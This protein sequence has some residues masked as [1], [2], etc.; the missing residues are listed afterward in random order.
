MPVSGPDEREM[1]RLARE[2]WLAGRKAY[3]EYTRALVQ[4]ARQVDH[5]VKGFHTGTLFPDAALSNIVDALGRYSDLLGPWAEAV[6]E[7][8][9]GD[10]ARRDRTA[11]H[12][13][14]VAI[15][16]R[17]REEVA[18]APIGP[19]LRLAQLEQVALIKSLP[20]EAAL[21]VQDLAQYTFLHGGRST[22]M[23]A[24]ILATG[25]VTKNRARLIARDQTAKLAANLTMVR[26]LHIGS[27]SYIWRTARDQRV[28]PTHRQ[29][30]GKT[31]TWK[32]K[33]RLSDGHLVNPGIDIQCRCWSEVIVE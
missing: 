30:D 2:R 32:D 15:G 33:A 20:R 26:A 22:E 21:R 24:A 10:V 8:M 6:A 5:I 29:V 7:R 1:R 4:V 14:G 12:Q 19:A 31:F 11:W 16:R 13:H 9:C 27:E 23:D 25:E 28:R 18:S 17:L 3:T